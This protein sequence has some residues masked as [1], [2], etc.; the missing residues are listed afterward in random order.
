MKEVIMEEIYELLNKYD[1]FKNKKYELIPIQDYGRSNK[2]KLKINNKFY[3]IIIDR[4]KVKLYSEKLE[5]LGIY[6]EELIGLEYLSKDNLVIIIDYPGE[7]NGENINLLDGILDIT[8]NLYIQNFKNI[9]DSIHSIKSDYINFSSNNICVNWYQYIY[10]ELKEKLSKVKMLGGI[11]EENEKNILISLEKNKELFENAEMS[12]IHADITMLNV[13][14]NPEKKELYLIDYDDFKIGDKIFDY[15]R[16][17]NC[18]SNS[19]FKKMV[20]LY[21]KEYE[22][23]F[24]HHIYTLRV[25]LNWYR[26]I[27]EKNLKNQYELPTKNI[28]LLVDKIINYCNQ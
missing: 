24:Q 27:I 19:L 5:K 12:F 23:T 11:S 21:Y 10:Q 8:E 17:I 16:I 4:E 9:V 20:E 28:M 1:Y 14:I 2:Y 7:N 18:S 6:F 3:T 25:E 26:H 15:S 13:C 22:N